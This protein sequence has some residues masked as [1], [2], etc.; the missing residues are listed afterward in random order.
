LTTATAYSKVE[1]GRTVGQLP[2]ADQEAADG[3]GAQGHRTGAGDHTTIGGKHR[4]FHDT[5]NESCATLDVLP[6]D[7]APIAVH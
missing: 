5:L 6:A 4:Y 1:P 2:F 3:T 7:S